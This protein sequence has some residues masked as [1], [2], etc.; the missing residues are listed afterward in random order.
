MFQEELAPV[1]DDLSAKWNTIADN[2]RCEHR[3]FVCTWCAAPR[4][5]FAMPA[6]EKRPKEPL[7]S[8]DWAQTVL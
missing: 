1:M 4:D 8:G 2:R 3:S 7:M 5:P 6:K